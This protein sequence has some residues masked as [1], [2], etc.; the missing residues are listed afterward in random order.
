[1]DVLPRLFNTILES[2]TMRG[3]RV[4][5]RPVVNVEAGVALF[6]TSNEKHTLKTLIK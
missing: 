2:E 6:N 1:M 3:T 5:C 4:M